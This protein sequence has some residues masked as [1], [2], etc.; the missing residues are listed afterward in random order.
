MMKK[1][2]LLG[3][4]LFTAILSNAQRLSLYEEFSGENCVPC[5]ATNPDLMVLLNANP[6]K[7]LLIKY[8]S[9]IPT[10][11]PIYDQ[12][13]TEVNTK[14]SYYSIN[15][16]PSGVMDG[17]T[18][19]H[20]ANLTQAQITAAAAVA[21]PF[22]MTV[23]NTITGNN[24]TA[25]VNI[26][27]SAVFA[28]GNMK[29]RVALVEDL[30]Y[31]TAPGTNGE[32]SFHHVM[33]KMLADGTAVP[34]AWTAGQTQAFTTTSMAIPS[35]IDRTHNVFVIAWIQD[36]T[37]KKVWQSTA[38]APVAG[39]TLD[40]ALLITS[41]TNNALSCGAGTVAHK[42]KIK[43]TGTTTL[44]SVDI[45]GKIGTGA[46]TLLQ[47]WT[48]SLAAGQ[49]TPADIVLSD[50]TFPTS[51]IIITDSVGNVNATADLNPANNATTASATKLVTGAD[52]P[53]S[54]GFD[55]SMAAG[56][57]VFDN[58]NQVVSTS[59]GSSGNDWFAGQNQAAMGPD[60][61]LGAAGAPNFN[62]DPGYTTVVTFPYANMPAGS[63]A[64]DFYYAHALRGTVGDKLD[65]VYST[66]C[67]Q[68][69]T[70]V[71]SKSA[72]DLVTAPATGVNNLFV[73]TPTQWKMASVSLDAATGNALVGFK[74][75]SNGGNYIFVDKVTLRTGT[76]TGIEELVTGGNI[77][78]YPNPVNN[79]MNVDINMIKS[80][81]VTFNIVNVLG[82]QIGSP[83]VKKL[84]AGQNMTQISTS[85]LTT[86][87]YFLN[88]STER[89][90]LQQK[91]VK[92]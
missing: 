9:P 30:E 47:T 57:L 13:P 27:S 44:T 68:N 75:T 48:G 89:G 70:S 52:L 3:G 67:G 60:N 82:Q 64:V 24:I 17:G 42:V 36:E 49:T 63:K 71:W 87:I 25:T 90:N 76:P 23:A 54:T 83:I 7:V 55:G 12:N 39:V 81:N 59:K 33:R 1:T 18:P 31:T 32:T 73:P 35:Y 58:T 16:A 51:T 2:L 92:Q 4:L 77:S 79:E 26:T 88:I 78:I 74:S 69:W 10:A 15:S 91:F 61:S 53:Q 84:N 62:S 22:T 8:Q 56:Y 50:L 45:Y 37:G 46:A 86:G 5:A 21:T 14:L 28:G 66:D 34:N 6:T 20:P 38:S 41:P 85:D 19:A 80:A 43:N 40:A 65:V 11:G 72:A 29:L